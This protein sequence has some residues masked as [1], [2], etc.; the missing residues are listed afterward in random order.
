M[1]IKESIGW[2]DMTL[3]PIKGLCQGHCVLPDG[4]HYCYYSG[5]RGLAR[6]FHHNPALMLDLSVFDRLPQEPRRI[7]LCSTHDLMGLWVPDEWRQQILSRV[8]EY[9]QHTFQMLT[10][11]PPRLP[12]F[13]PLPP[14]C[15]VGVTATDVP[16]FTKAAKYL[17]D[18]DAPLK[19]LSFEPLLN[20]DEKAIDDVSIRVILRHAG[21][22]WL[23][24]GRL[25]GFGHKYDP[26]VEWI[27]DI[28]QAADQAGIPVFQKDNLKPLLGENLRQEMPG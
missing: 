20:W 3:N 21:I 14:N 19:Y 25:T 10:K 23:I 12:E 11:F 13:E 2:T 16:M 8:S 22:S 6:R 15:W 18:V 5:D 24:I 27:A 26:K 28:V 9:P 1:S 7:F 4:R 17:A